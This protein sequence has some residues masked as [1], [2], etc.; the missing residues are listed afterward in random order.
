MVCKNKKKRGLRLLDCSYLTLFLCEFALLSSLS[1]FISSF[2]GHSYD[3]TDCL[4]TLGSDS[5]LIR[6]VYRAEI[7]HITSHFGVTQLVIRDQSPWKPLVNTSI[8]SCVTI[9][10][11][12]FLFLL[13]WQLN[14]REVRTRS[15]L[16][17]EG[18]WKMSQPQHAP[19]LETF[20]MGM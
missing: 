1:R 17:Q 7:H 3:E 13:Y 6:V 4:E 2:H 19:P 5:A 8:C 20:F 18:A 15:W 10:R 11:N 14:A 16:G 9:K 12:P